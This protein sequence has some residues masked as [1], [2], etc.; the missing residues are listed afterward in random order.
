MHRVRPPGTTS[1]LASSGNEDSLQGSVAEMVHVGI[2]KGADELLSRHM[3]NESIIARITEWL[4]KDL[5]RFD[6]PEWRVAD[7]RLVL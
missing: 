1:W 6:Y 5:Q 4:R 3:R 2:N 7:T